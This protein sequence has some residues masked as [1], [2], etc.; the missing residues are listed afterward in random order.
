ATRCNAFDEFYAVEHGLGDPVPLGKHQDVARLQRFDRLVQ[1]RT[2]DA[3]SARQ[4]L[5]ENS[6]ATLGL[7]HCELPIEVLMGR[8]YA[9][10]AD[11]HW[12]PISASKTRYRKR[13][14]Q[15]LRR[16]VGSST[17]SDEP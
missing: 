16:A 12:L 7:E 11:E 5:F 14:T 2:P 9:R 8:R 13:Y 1:L 4:L 3:F 15:Q 17:T 10:I 6:P